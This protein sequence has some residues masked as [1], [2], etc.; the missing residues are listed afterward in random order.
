MP[1][2]VIAVPANQKAEAEGQPGLPDDFKASPH[3]L[4][5]LFLNIKNNEKG[6]KKQV[7]GSCAHARSLSI[8]INLARTRT[9]TH[10]HTHTHTP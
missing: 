2:L 10:T 4:V 5:R 7:D 1:G 8:S 6:C 9:Y 3:N